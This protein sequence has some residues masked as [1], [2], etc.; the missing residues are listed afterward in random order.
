VAGLRLRDHRQPAVAGRVDGQRPGREP[1]V[2]D[3]GADRVSRGQGA[4]T[5]GQYAGDDQPFAQGAAAYTIVPTL[6]DRRTQA[7]MGTLKL[8]RDSYPSMSG[9]PTFRSTPA[10]AMPA[11][12]GS[13]R[14]S[15]MARAAASS[16]IA[17]CSS[18]CWRH[19][20]SRRWREMNSI[21]AGAAAGCDLLILRCGVFE[22]IG[23]KR[24]QPSAAPTVVHL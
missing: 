9:K 22:K 8:L 2:G 5:H 19:N 15:S 11:G 24:S 16:P 18:I 4:G 13:R 1:A 20:S 3:S 17:P 12:Q 10:C 6:F 21:H 14:R 23:I 7:S